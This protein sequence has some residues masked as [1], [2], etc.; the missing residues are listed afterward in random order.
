MLAPIYREM[1]E[2]YYLRTFRD[3]LPTRLGSVAVIAALTA[4]LQVWPWACA[5]VWAM[6]YLAA[7]LAMIAWWRRAQPGL[8]SDDEDRIRA[9]QGQLIAICA[10]ACAITAAP[11]FFTPLGGHDRA[12]LG[13]ILASG[14]LLVAAAS[15]SLTRNMILMTT[16]AAAIALEWNLFSL[17]HGI[18][19]WVFAGLGLAFVAN[20][21]VL[22]LSNATVFLDL[23][24]LR[25]GAEAANT[26]KSDFLATMSHEIR[27]PLNGVLGMVQAMQR[28]RPTALQ[29]ERLQ[30]IGESGETLLAVLGD[31]LDLSKI[32]AGKLVLETT[33]F[34]LPALARGVETNFAPMAQAKGLEFRLDVDAAAMGAWR[35]DPI[36]VRQVLY[37]LV[38]NALKFTSAGAVVVTIGAGEACGVRIGVSDTGIGMSP[39][40]VGRL[41]GKFVQADSSMTRRFGGTGLGLAIS[42]ELCRAMGGEIGVESRAGQGSRFVVELPLLRARETVGAPAAAS[43]PPAPPGR[44]RVLAAE[45]NAM[46]QLVLKTLLGQVGLEPVMVADGAEAV[47]AWEQGAWD[48]VLMD[49]QMP[50]MDGLSA[51]RAIRRR[52]AVAGRAPTPIIALTAN[53][54]TH[55]V[56]SYLAAGMD[57]FVP[58]PIEATRLFAAI[59]AAVEGAPAS[60]A[61]AA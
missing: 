42:R 53:A 59:A 60:D 25:V 54:M 31:I 32:E 21:R 57:A 34:D 37:N 14:V 33:D 7:E 5:V 17:G 2:K 12:I 41:F 28:D 26:A 15:H 51:T 35:G 27:T 29:R 1:L 4:Y 24:R 45:D 58:K 56:E 44:L 30:L 22:Q 36:R 49:V 16:P 19:A 52:E 47:A 9:L 43:P 11:C 46:N 40:A 18:Y 10:A 55:Q 13:V 38:S 20:A 3:H 39:E 8:N 50:V 6:A 23:V 61:N 48:V